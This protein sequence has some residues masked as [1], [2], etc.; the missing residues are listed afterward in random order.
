[1]TLIAPR[2][3]ERGPEIAAIAVS[4]GLRPALRSAG[5]TPDATT[6]IYVC[7]TVGELGIMFRVAPIVF[8]GGSL[9]AH[10][11]QN[12][13]EAIKLGAAILHGP[14]ISNFAEIYAALDGARGAYLIADAERL[15]QCAGVW[16]SDAEARGRVVGAGQK[17]VAALGGALERTLAALDPYLMQLSLEN[18]GNA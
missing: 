5:K 11:G 18:R 6:D 10:G 16:L 7:D 2:H 3:P 9:I 17:T 8:M 1:M 15:A 13:I 14:S 12:P 4:F